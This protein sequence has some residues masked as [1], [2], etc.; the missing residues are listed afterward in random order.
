MKVLFLANTWAQ[1]VNA[2]T[3]RMTE[4][5][6][7]IC[8]LCYAEGIQ[9]YVEGTG[10]HTFSTCYYRPKLKKRSMDSLIGKTVNWIS[11]GLTYKNLLHMFPVDP[12]EYDRV[13]IP[14][15][16]LEYY[17]IFYAIYSVNPT[18]KL[19]LYEEGI[20]E[21][22][23]LGK[24]DKRKELYS[25]VFFGCYSYAVCDSLYVHCP[26][27]VNNIWDNI[28]VKKMST[29]V[30]E[31]GLPQLINS[32]FRYNQSKQI[33]TKRIVFIDQSYNGL[34]TQEERENEQRALFNQISEWVGSDNLIVKL[35]PKSP[36]KKYGE[37]YSYIEEQYPMELIG[38]NENTS[39]KVFITVTSSA[40]VNFKLTLGQEPTVII[41]QRIL[42]IENGTHNL[43][44]DSI[45]YK[46]KS[47]YSGDNFVIPES[48]NEL[49]DYLCMID[50]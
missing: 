14:G 23:T 48:R 50:D 24:K 22:Y 5:M 39:D 16:A 20:C 33:F 26:E 46:V 35:H 43:S 1:Y 45:F 32:V 12:K 29:P 41:L 15:I 25:R 34:A 21:Y 47:M 31:E 2:I 11:T 37:H 10:E 36:Q 8:D 4:F 49:Y 40:A 18:V 44:K 17:L 38:M 30:E 19:S 13:L 42:D 28:S 7:D 27:A 9:K 6:S 3:L